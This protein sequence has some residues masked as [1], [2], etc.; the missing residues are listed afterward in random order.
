MIG[1]G[2]V[3]G[4]GMMRVYRLRGIVAGFLILASGFTASFS[5]F[6]QDAA[7]V[8][9]YLPHPP[10][11]VNGNTEFTASNGVTGGS[12]TPED[13]Y[14][15]QGWRI[16]GEGRLVL[17]NYALHIR[18]TTAAFVIQD[19]LVR[20]ARRGI[21]LEGVTDGRVEN[22]VAEQNTG[23]IVVVSSARVHV[24]GNRATRNV[25]GVEIIAS[26]SVVVTA[27]NVS[28]NVGPTAGGIIHLSGAGVVVSSSSDVLI[29]SN[30]IES[31]R[32][33]GI[34][35]TGT[36]PNVTVRGNRISGHGNAGVSFHDAFGGAATRNSFTS[37]FLEIRGSSGQ[38]VVANNFTDGG[39]HVEHSDNVVID[40]NV[41][42]EGT[43]GL[44]L[45][46]VS[47]TL[48]GNA[49]SRGGLS[50]FPQQTPVEAWRTLTIT[51]N[52][53]NGKPLLFHEDCAGLNI[54]GVPVG[55]L[56][57]ANCKNV[58][59]ANLEI[60]NTSVGITMAFVDGA[61][62]TGNNV[63]FNTGP[64]MV[65]SP[66]VNSVV[67]ENVLAHN[68]GNTVCGLLLENAFGV[69][70]YH[71]DFIGN[72]VCWDFRGENAWDNG[73]PAGGNYWADYSGEDLCRGPA[74]EVCDGPD[75]IGDVAYPMGCQECPGT[76]IL[77]RYP[78][79]SPIRWGV[80]DGTPP[81]GEDG[82]TPGGLS[83]VFLGLLLGSAV[84]LPAAV[85]VL[86]FRSWR[87]Q[88]N[89]RPPDEG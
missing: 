1:G 57:V 34:G 6:P 88:R 24:E 65:L 33:D 75:G 10:I 64:G 66:V 85:L 9:H 7:A 60:T 74:Q 84:A 50:T 21:F 8:S 5:L 87:R 86:V 38:E 68:I 43:I 54:D 19:V 44:G 2:K 11:F 26:S 37:D 36:L 56:I 12:G 13:P 42:D 61:N 79:M 35:L 58:R 59:V 46:V 18:D 53:V 17:G 48:R 51:E 52:T 81:P 32:D 47:I 27:N 72:A 25:A 69:R 16:E 78:L 28:A 83:P 40:G 22:S 45:G 55:Q 76:P 82:T 73:Y 89:E 3:L 49:M 80:G 20:Q 31:N 62:V 63:S 41:L 77:D 70:V 15:I 67:S 30:E 14:L 39:I 4:G 23:G 29:Q 71:N